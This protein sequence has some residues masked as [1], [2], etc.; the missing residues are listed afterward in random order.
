MIPATTVGRAKGRSI[1]E[2]TIRLPGKLSLTRTQAIAV[3]VTTLITTTITEAMRVSFRARIARGEVSDVQNASSPP[4]VD[5]ATRAAIGIRTM[6]LR[7]AVTRPRPRAAPP[8]RGNLAGLGGAAAR[9]AGLR[10]SL[11]S[12]PQALRNQ[13]RHP[14][15]TPRS[16]SILATLP[17]SGSKN[18][19]LAFSQPP[20]LG[21]ST[22]NRPGGVGNLSLFLASTDWST[23]R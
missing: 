6:R 10:T 23:G 20:M 12:H 8:R 21:S 13:G 5:L 11:R 22:V 17:F 18:S 2:F 3:P 15:E 7:Y 9:A 19:V 16:L 4:P 1:T 14:V